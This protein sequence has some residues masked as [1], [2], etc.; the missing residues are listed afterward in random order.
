[1]SQTII[2]LSMFVAI[3]SAV[4]AQDTPS[5]N[6]PAAESAS[7]PLTDLMP[8]LGAPTTPSPLPGTADAWVVHVTRSGGFIGGVHDDFTLNSM[9]KFSCVVREVACGAGDLVVR[10]EAISPLTSMIAQARLSIPENTVPGQKAIFS[11]CSDC[12]TNGVSLWR[13]VSGQEASYRGEWDLTTRGA[14]PP[15]ILKL[16]DAVMKVAPG[17][18]AATSPRR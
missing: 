18:T 1:M 10:A 3:Q 8:F 16:F 14:I 5:V 6:P 2:W 17:Q 11:T 9:G 4:V 15:D 12:V 7:T 13:R